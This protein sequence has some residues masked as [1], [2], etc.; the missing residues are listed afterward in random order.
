MRKARHRAA[1]LAA[2]REMIAER[3]PAGF[4]TDDLAVRAGLSRR[5][6]FNHFAHL[7]DVVVACAEAELEA[8][9]LAAGRDL[10]VAAGAH[11]HPL[12]DL[13]ALLTAPDVADVISRLGRVFAAPGRE[14]VAERIRRQA[15]REFGTA[16]VQRLRERY[17]ATPVVD[18]DLL[19]TS[20][21]GG[22]DVVASTW[23]RE[24]GGVLDPASR[25][26]F[27]ELM[28]THLGFVR[29]GFGTDRPRTTAA[30]S[31]SQKGR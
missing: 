16:A 4:T 25:A 13:E 9:V 30:S 20:V 28:T 6:V 19:T 5:T 12:D 1:L 22:A 24:T 3:G 21:M 14:E 26:R 31:P 17:P 10:G 23:L 29:H 2:A 8:V 15:M 27:H 18:L 11:V 7:E